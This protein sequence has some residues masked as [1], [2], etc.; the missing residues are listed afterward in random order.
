MNSK[1]YAECVGF[2]LHYYAGDEVIPHL[3]FFTFTWL[4]RSEK[5]LLHIATFILQKKKIIIINYFGCVEVRILVEKWNIFEANIFPRSL[6][7]TSW[8]EKTSLCL[9]TRLSVNKKFSP[10]QH[11]Y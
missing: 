10:S 2:V 4:S 7:Q 8:L 1:K 6:V 3:D 9:N 11:F 5:W